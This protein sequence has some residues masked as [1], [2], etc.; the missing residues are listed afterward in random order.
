MPKIVDHKAHSQDLAQR[1]A[2][3]FSDHG[4]AGTSMR[5]V[6]A[7]LG[8]SKSALYHYF[9]TKEHLFLACTRQVMGGLDRTFI[10]ATASDE[11]NLAQLKEVLRKDFASEMA[12]V[13]EYLRGK[14]GTEIANDEA[15]KVAMDAYRKMVASIV[16]EDEAEE[17]LARLFGSLM[18]DYMSGR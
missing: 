15:M 1:A 4:Y 10:D 18:L 6:A 8:L 11:E 14:S 2:K 5:K 12:L 3:Y 17:H 9:P 16:G 13:F 7:Y